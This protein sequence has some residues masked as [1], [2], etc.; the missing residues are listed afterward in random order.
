MQTLQRHRLEST[1]NQSIDKTIQRTKQYWYEDGLTE[2]GTAIVFAA[3]SCVFL[4]DALAPDGSIMAVSSAFLLPVAVMG[5]IFVTRRLVTWGKERITYPRSGF[6]AYRQ[7]SRRLRSVAV[8]VA[9]AVAIGV[10]LLVVGGS[11]IESSTQY[12]PLFTA[13][14]IG[15]FMLYIGASIGI[16]RYY[17]VAVA[18]VIL[19]ALA[20]RAF[21]DPTEGSAVYFALMAAALAISGTTALYRYLRANEQVVDSAASSGVK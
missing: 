18:S 3:I 10:A 14:I 7:P 13:S 21:P 15:M 9:A 17:M 20:V 16:V 19:G 4:I 2:L 11:I 6:V 12:V 1:V 8:M 5:G